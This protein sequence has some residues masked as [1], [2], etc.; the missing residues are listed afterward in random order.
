MPTCSRLIIPRRKKP[1][2][3]D[4]RPAVLTKNSKRFWYFTMD[5]SARKDVILRD[6]N[7]FIQ[8]HWQV[9]LV[10]WWFRVSVYF[11]NRV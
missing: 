5:P 3:V 11:A 1:M 6:G 2:A 9:P 7:R 4:T 10:P 8:I